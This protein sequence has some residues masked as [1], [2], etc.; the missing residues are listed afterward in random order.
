[1][2]LDIA[3]ISR[4]VLVHSLLRICI[5]VPGAGDANTQGPPERG[6]GWPQG[7]GEGRE[8]CFCQVKKRLYSDLKLYS[9]TYI[10]YILGH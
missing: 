3:A 1:M 7:R 2:L 6:N 4:S 9:E 10:V 8:C 5:R